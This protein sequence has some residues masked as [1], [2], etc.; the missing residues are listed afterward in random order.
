MDGKQEIRPVNHT[1]Y[2]NQNLLPAPPGSED[3]EGD[4]LNTE[5]KKNLFTYGGSRGSSAQQ[6][7]RNCKIC[8]QEASLAHCSSANCK[9]P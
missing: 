3:L 5:S 4:F 1:G 6:W 7:L 8:F 9:L 2:Y